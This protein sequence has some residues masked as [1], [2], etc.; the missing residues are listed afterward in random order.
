MGKLKLSKSFRSRQS[1]N[2]LWVD[3]EGQLMLTAYLA[4]PRAAPWDNL[5]C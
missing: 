1:A 2:H 3:S 4:C 5:S